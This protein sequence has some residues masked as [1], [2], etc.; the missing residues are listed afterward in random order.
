[1]PN[2][3]ILNS[4]VTNLSR[5]GIRRADVEFLV[6]Y[7][8]DMARIERIVLE[9]LAREPRVLTEPAPYV[10]ITQ[11]GASGLTMQARPVVRYVEYDRFM[12]D[13]RGLIK[14]ALEAEG[15]NLATPHQSIHLVN[16]QSGGDG[17]GL[18][19]K[20]RTDAANL[21]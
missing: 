9:A 1:M 17:V 10:S 13:A 6:E 20:S 15:I 14:N 5:L 2:G 7:G 18:P 21:N 4:G 19:V 3:E 8:Q 11:L 16:D 12:L